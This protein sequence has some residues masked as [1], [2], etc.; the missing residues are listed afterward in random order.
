MPRVKAQGKTFNF[1]E[2]TTQEQIGQAIDDYFAN[3]PAPVS[4]KGDLTA[5][6]FQEQFGDIPDI[7]GRIAAP[8]PK[9]EASFADQVIGAGE[10]ALTTLSGAT[11]GTAGMLTGF[12]DQ[13]I[14]EVAEGK[15]GTSEAANR[16]ANR[17]AEL[18]ASTTYQ[19]RTEEG[20]ETLETIG[21]VGE[22]L[23]PLAGLGG[24]VA[25][26]TQLASRAAPQARTAIESAS[27]S[28]VARQV[29]RAATGAAQDAKEVKQAIFSRQS[30]VKQEIAR[31]IEAGITDVDTAPFA[32][33][34]PTPKSKPKSRVAQAIS[35][36]AP[37]VKADKLAVDAIDQGFDEGV[38]ASIKGSVPSDRSAMRKML[39]IYER[40]TKNATYRAKNRPTDVIGDRIVDT[41][42]IVKRA[43]R[44]AAKGINEAAES[45]KG[46]YVDAQQIGNRF[47]EELRDAGVSIG[48]DLKLVFEGSDFEDLP[49]VERTFKTVFRRMAAKKRPD[50]YELHRMKRFIDEQ[51]SYGKGGEGLTGRAE[52]MLKSLRRDIDEMLDENFPDYNEA[53][54]IYADTIQ[55]LDDIQDVA[56]RK[57]DLD[58]P[59][60]NKALGTTMR[61]LLSNNKGRVAIMDAVQNI[62]ETA[63]KYPGQLLLEGPGGVKK[64]PDITQLIMFADELDSRFGPTARTSFQGQI[65]QVAQ[66]GRQAAASP[67]G[68]AADAVVSLAA[69]GYDKV[70]GVSDEKALAALKK[71]LKEDK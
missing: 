13:T 29:A 57:I 4:A 20:V 64:K 9:P 15:F 51:V 69:K 63:R 11:T 7:E 46:R 16:I 68:A 32:L 53:N 3:N 14:K 23:A 37:T 61:G 2:G 54:T 65:E 56:G 49:A 28:P 6:Q 22:A 40:G 42:N 70:R 55:A 43:N 50:A 60:A 17:A 48:D 52:G 1:P 59:N 58:G 71:L 33:D 5:E 8:E 21:E 41:V 35:T 36:G 62:E 24:S 34:S 44:K 18:Q 12:I 30:P 39:G 38:I 19:P 31:K 47:V 10:A 66:R 67:T 25:Q 45:L 26:A 27:R